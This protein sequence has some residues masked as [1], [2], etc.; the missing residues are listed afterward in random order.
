MD[1]LTVL[2]Q[3]IP[4][5][6][7]QQSAQRHFKRH[8]RSA[9]HQGSLFQLPPRVEGAH[10]YAHPVEPN[11]AQGPVNPKLRTRWEL[12]LV[13]KPTRKVVRRSNAVE[14]HCSGF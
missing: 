11:N 7:P 13:L 9:L 14:R 2:E 12:Q 10:G 5:R 4:H 1:D 3:Q 8:D 6:R